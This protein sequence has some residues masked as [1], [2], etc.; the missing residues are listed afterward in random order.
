M[1]SESWVKRMNCVAWGSYL[2]SGSAI[3]FH[4]CG[5]W[6]NINVDNS[7]CHKLL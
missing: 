1:K 7:L 6:L 5:S 3:K 4:A 2:D